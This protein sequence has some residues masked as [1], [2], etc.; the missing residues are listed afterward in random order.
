[1]NEANFNLDT[2]TDTTTIY[3]YAFRYA[4]G[5]RTFAP[6]IVTDFLSRNLSTMSDFCIKKMIKEIDECTDYGDNCDRDIWLAFRSDL[7][8]ALA[9]RAEPTDS[10]EEER[11]R[12]TKAEDDCQNALENMKSAVKDAIEKQIKNADNV[13]HPSHYCDGKIEVIDYIEDKKLNYHLGN[14]VKYISR[15]GKKDENKTIE[16]LKKAR[17]YLDRYI[18]KLEATKI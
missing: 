11:I 10:N 12:W 7:E 14:V 15:A 3:L 9:L 17:W 16:D 4:L 6:I 13:N 2:N 8:D 5:R 1:M 18:T